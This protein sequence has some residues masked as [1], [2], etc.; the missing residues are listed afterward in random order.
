MDALHP[1]G[2]GVR[3]K[4]TLSCEMTIS[5]PIP[6]ENPASTAWGTFE[7]YRPNRSTQK[8]RRKTDA[9]TQIFAAPLIPP[10]RTAPRMNGTVALEVPPI[11]TGFLPRRAQMGADRSDV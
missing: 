10:T 9:K 4:I 11:R 8:I 7:T 5:P 1:P 6:Q 2:G 3:A